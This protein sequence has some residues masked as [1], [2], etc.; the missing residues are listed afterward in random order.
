MAVAGHEL[1]AR[2]RREGARRGQVPTGDDGD[3]RD[4]RELLEGGEGSGGDTGVLGAGNDGG[5][6]PVEVAGDEHG[7]RTARELAE[8]ARERRVQRHAPSRAPRKVRPQAWASRSR[9]AATS[10]SL[11]RPGRLASASRRAHLE[12]SAFSGSMATRP[13]SS[14]PA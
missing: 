4:R 7:R 10:R 13:S 1:D 6:G 5:E 9:T 3:V 11:T 14:K 2:H 8:A 12:D